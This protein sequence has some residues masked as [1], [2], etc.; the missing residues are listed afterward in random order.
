MFYLHKLPLQDLQEVVICSTHGLPIFAAICARSHSGPGWELV[1]AFIWSN[2][3]SFVQ[4]TRRFDGD[5]SD[6][7]IGDF[8]DSAEHFEN[9]HL[10]MKSEERPE[11]CLHLF[12]GL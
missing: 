8:M 5:P 2:H 1:T 10:T 9:E 12:Q 3:L 6:W 7:T 11:S 4:R